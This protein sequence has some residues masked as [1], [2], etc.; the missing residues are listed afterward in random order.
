MAL[1]ELGAVGPV[2][3]RDVGEARRLGTD[4]AVEL[5]LA[6]G[7]GQM[8]VAA[9]D[10]GD[11]HVD[12]VDD[13]REHVGGRAV[14]AQQHHVVELL[15]GD[16][17]GALHEILDDGLALLRRP[18]ADDGL[19]AGRRL[20]GI[21]VAPAA[22][23]A[24]R[25]ALGPGLGPH[26][27]QLLGRREAAIGL[28][29]VEEALDHLGVP[30]GAHELEDGRLVG[31]EAEPA[32]AVQDRLDRGLGRALAVGVLDAQKVAAAMVPGEQPVEER[33]PGTT[34]VQET[35]G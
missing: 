21:A 33:G 32:Q 28:A 12:V 15:V 30:A 35:C 19:H 34:D 18:E 25:P 4:R 6:E 29:L 26:R 8:V 31:G 22:V 9:D 2:D 14:R 5:G 13:D 23:I 11:A 7:V 17:H 24:E 27:V 16:P 20:G 10:V 3:H 1:A